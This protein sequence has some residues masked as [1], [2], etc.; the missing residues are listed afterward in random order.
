[1]KARKGS[2]GIAPLIL[3]LGTTSRRV[4]KFT[5]RSQLNMTMGGPQS[6]KSRF[7]QPKIKHRIAQR[8]AWS[9]HQLRCPPPLQVCQCNERHYT[10]HFNGTCDSDS[11]IVTEA[12]V[13]HW[14]VNHSVTWMGHMVWNPICLRGT[15]VSSSPPLFICYFINL[16]SRLLLFFAFLSLQVLLAFHSVR[17]IFSTTFRRISRW[18]L[19]GWWVW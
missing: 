5:P 12:K 14:N 13:N 2:R 16:R 6:V 17:T 15:F 10:K 1:M 18:S 19:Q 4:D 7:L 9:L 11:A 3:N 8:T